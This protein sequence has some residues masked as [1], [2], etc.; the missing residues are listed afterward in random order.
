MRSVFSNNYLDDS[1]QPGGYI[2]W[3]AT[4]PRINNSTFQLEYNDYG[5][6]VNMTARLANYPIT[7]ELTAEQFAEYD[8]PDK[9]FQYVDGRFGNTAWIDQGA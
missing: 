9:V 6:G 8:S 4:D 7:Q 3:Q 2:E 1:I 5:P